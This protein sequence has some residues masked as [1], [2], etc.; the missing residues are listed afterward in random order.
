MEKEKQKLYISII[1][2]LVVLIVLVS[3]TLDL[4]DK[5]KVVNHVKVENGVEVVDYDAIENEVMVGQLNNMKERDRMEYY[6]TTFLNYAEDGEYSK[7][8]KMMNAAFKDKYF[9]T[10]ED[11]RIYADKH[12]PSMEDKEFTNIERQDKTYYMWVTIKDVLNGKRNDPGEEYTFVILE[13]DLN[14]IE[15]SFSVKE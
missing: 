11:F 12:F 7:A 13:K 5:Q 14:D 3:L 1:V 8:Y 4:R 6:I 9:P 15:L 2:V 10:E